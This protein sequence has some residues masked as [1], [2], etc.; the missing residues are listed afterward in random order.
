[1]E[2]RI[3]RG[4]QDVLNPTGV[5]VLR[6]MPDASIRIWG[7]RTLSADPVLQP[8]QVRAMLNV[9][10]RSIEQGT[11]WAIFQRQDAA[12][13]RRVCGALYGFLERTW[14]SGALAGETARDAFYVA[15]DRDPNDDDHLVVTLGVAILTAREFQTLRVVFVSELAPRVERD[16]GTALPVQKNSH[17]DHGTAVP[18][19]PS[20]PTEDDAAL[21]VFLSYGREDWTQFVQPLVEALRD[22]GFS[23]WI[24]QHLLRGGQDWMDAINAAL[25]ACPVMVLCVSPDSMASKHVKVEYRYFFNM[26]KTIVPLICRDASLPAE[27]LGLQYLAYSD[28]AA[29]VDRLKE[30]LTL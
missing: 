27:L 2:L 22:E 7:A 9:I 17:P 24:D 18:A 6:V 25:K 14:K 20:K 4:E 15:D 30:L 13:R 29:L 23:V 8:V 19:R 16:P 21:Q 26:D 28:R 12:L 5:N 3:S 10:E 1:M 11:S